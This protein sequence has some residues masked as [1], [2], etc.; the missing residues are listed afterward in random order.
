MRRVSRS[1]MVAGLDAFEKLV[2]VMMSM[3]SRPGL[4]GLS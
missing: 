1:V 2:V 4:D 3:S